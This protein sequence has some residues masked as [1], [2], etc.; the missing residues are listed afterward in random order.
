MPFIGQFLSTVCFALPNVYIDSIQ[1]CL[2]MNGKF[3]RTANI[4]KSSLKTQDQATQGWPASDLVPFSFYYKCSFQKSV[5][6]PSTMENKYPE[7][8]RKTDIWCEIC[9]WCFPNYFDFLGIRLQR[10]LS[11]VA[12]PVKGWSICLRHFARD[13]NCSR[14][15]IVDTQLPDF[16]TQMSSETSGAPSTKNLIW[17]FLFWIV[18]I[19][20]VF[21]ST[22]CK[23]AAKW[24]SILV[25]IVYW[26]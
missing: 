10:F 6:E 5:E 25:F 4:R 21:S 12:V 2:L 3:S 24:Y 13:Q 20:D 17:T 18:P 1:I 9:P 11:S 14:E 22:S 23:V 8:T 15:N 19:F 16:V 7:K 26:A